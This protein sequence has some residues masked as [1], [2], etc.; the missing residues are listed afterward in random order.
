MA[1]RDLKPNYVMEVAFRHPCC[2]EILRVR[3]THYVDKHTSV[4]VASEFSS[5]MLAYQLKLLIERHDCPE[6]PDGP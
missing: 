6:N 3:T 5:R 1:D 2:D 4:A